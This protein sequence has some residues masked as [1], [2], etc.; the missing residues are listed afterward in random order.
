MIKTDIQVRFSDIDML[1]HVNNV[2]LQQYYDLGKTSYLS[3]VLALSGLWK[4]V[5]YIVVNTNTNYMGEVFG[6]RKFHVTTRISRIGSKSIT[7]VQEIVD[8]VTEVVKS[9][10][11]SVLVAFDLKTREGILVS[12]DHRQ[13]IEAHEGI[14]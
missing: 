2:V 14:E 7:F 5:S 3:D 4:D 12:D 8:S 1:G 6:D 10:S 13:K 9:R 11:E